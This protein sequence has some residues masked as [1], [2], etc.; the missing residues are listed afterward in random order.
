[1]R[2]IAGRFRRR[3]IKAPDGRLTRPTTDRTRESLFNLVES[4]MHL[5]GAHVLDL[6]CGSGAIGLEAISRGAEAATFLD[7]DGRVLKYARDNAE[8][9]E[10]GEMCEFIRADAVPY[11][12]K[13]SGPPFDLIV[14]DPPYYL[15]SIALLP[16]LVLP[17][18]SPDG[19]FAL[20]HDARI[21]LDHHPHLETSR[22]YGR[23]IVSIF[24]PEPI[25]ED[26]EE[27]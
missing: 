21:V 26:E 2:I 10:V 13:Y 24:H 3:Q 8:L 1:M 9:L 12:K 17:H 16:E 14:A 20:E 22:A 23:T 11:M 6:F 27:Q 25:E 15:P 18:V 19:I 5:A 4:R 7:S